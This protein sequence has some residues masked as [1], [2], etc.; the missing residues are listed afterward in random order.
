LP[1]YY[2]KCLLPS[3][4]LFGA[5]PFYNPSWFR[6]PLSPD[7][8][9]ILWFR[10]PV[11]LRFWVCQ[12]LGSQASS[13]T[14]RSWCDQAP[15]LLG[16]WNPNILGVLQNLEVVSPL[17]TR[18]LSG[19]FETQVYH[20]WSGGTRAACQAGILCPCSCYHRP[21]TIGLELMLC[22]TQPWS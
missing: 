20:Y 16:S 18:G 10:A 2:L 13:E 3:I 6:T 9:V 11:N 22:S 8:S 15:V 12:N 14:L 19:V 17:R 7:F 5:C 1:S 4:Y 21:V